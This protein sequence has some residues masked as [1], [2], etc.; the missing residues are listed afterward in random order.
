[1][2]VEGQV[3]D[4]LARSGPPER[5][6]GP[7]DSDGPEDRDLDGVTAHAGERSQAHLVGA[8]GFEPSLGTV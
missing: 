1:M 7:T 3:H 2:A 6:N 8:E 5:A 4:E